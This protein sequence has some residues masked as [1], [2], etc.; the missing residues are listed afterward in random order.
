[1]DSTPKRN[2]TDEALERAELAERLRSAREY[3]GFS[4]DQ[5]A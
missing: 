1:M 4:Q 3:L 5:V 2:P